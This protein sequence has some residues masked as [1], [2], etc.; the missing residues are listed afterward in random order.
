MMHEPKTELI[1]RLINEAGA[2]VSHTLMK[3]N[4]CDLTLADYNM[5]VCTVLAK[6]AFNAGYTLAKGRYFLSKM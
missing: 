6:R 3:L 1:E 5:M 2:E 4:N